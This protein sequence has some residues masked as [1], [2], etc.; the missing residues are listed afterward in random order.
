[1]FIELIHLE[2]KDPFLMNVSELAC[3]AFE[4]GGKHAIICTHGGEIV[5]QES[6]LEVRN[7]LTVYRK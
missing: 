3:V 4:N 1:M 5:V 7:M 2:S 6:Y